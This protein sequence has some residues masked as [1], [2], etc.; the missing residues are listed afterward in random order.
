MKRIVLTIF[1]LALGVIGLFGQNG[2]RQPPVIGCAGLFWGSSIEDYQRFYPFSKESTR[3]G[4]PEKG[5]RVFTQEAI[6]Y[7]GLDSMELY[8]YQGRLYKVSITYAKRDPESVQYLLNEFES[9][10]GKFDAYSTS[11][12]GQGLEILDFVRSF[13]DNLIIQFSIIDE[14]GYDDMINIVYSDPARIE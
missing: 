9:T 3:L 8:F 10:Y 14:Q 5:I 13:S 6:R 1:L 2:Q 7:G 12:S 4:Q 11:R